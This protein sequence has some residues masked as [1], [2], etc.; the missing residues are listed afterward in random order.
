MYND[1]HFQEL[2]GGFDFG[3]RFF[4]SHDVGVK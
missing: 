4:V 2:Q 3:K 1:L